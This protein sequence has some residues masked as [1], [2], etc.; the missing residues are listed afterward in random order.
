MATVLTRTVIIYI[1]L[2]IS[3]RITGKRQIGELQISELVVT[4][5]L[6]ELAVFPITDKSIPLLHGILPIT[7]LLSLEV[8][9]SF[10]QTKS[11]PFRKFFCGGPCVLIDK[12]KLLPDVLAENRI[13]VEELFG[14]LRLKGVFDVSNVWYAVLEENGQ[15]SVLPKASS[16]AFTPDQLGL[17][18]KEHG[19]SHP[20][21]VDGEVNEAG[22]KS[23]GLNYKEIERFLKK[24]NITADNI[25][26][27]TADDTG[28]VLVYVTDKK[29]RYRIVSQKKYKI[30]DVE[31][32]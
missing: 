19:I 17:N 31:A 8:V 4:F 15:L 22:I 27:M 12:G 26:L 25:F 20:I 3:I 13:D 30:K 11:V 16:S 6:S 21:I 1:L 29:D 5:M 28:D 9:F 23:S 14:E 10:L 2:I 18:V 32:K 24:H 7:V